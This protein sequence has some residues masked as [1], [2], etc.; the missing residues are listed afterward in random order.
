M[1]LPSLSEHDIQRI[2][3]AVRDAAQVTGSL[4][5][6]EASGIALAAARTAVQENSA[7]LFSLLG[8]DIANSKD[9]SRLRA[10]L[11]FMD[12]MRRR[13]ESV[14]KAMSNAIAI[15]V[16]LFI[17]GLLALG[18]KGTIIGWLGHSPLTAIK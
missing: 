4:H 15:A 13:S 6:D 9:V 5:R 1:S 12:S 10:D 8:Y 11:D 16:A 18:A 17:L 7:K 2:A 14:G 3:A